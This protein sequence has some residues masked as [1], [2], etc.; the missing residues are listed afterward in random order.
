MVLH[1]RDS[2]HQQR[3]PPAPRLSPTHS[4][5]A[6]TFLPTMRRVL[7]PPAS[8]NCRFASSESPSASRHSASIHE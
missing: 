2:V 4:S 1:V 6:L 5:T 3:D 8:A 7:A